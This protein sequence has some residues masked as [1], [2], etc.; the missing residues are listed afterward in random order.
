LY[1]IGIRPKGVLRNINEIIGNSK[2]TDNEQ[3]Q[4]QDSKAEYLGDP[5]TPR[6]KYLTGMILLLFLKIHHIV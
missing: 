4:A 1:V 2:D 5:V 3:A 6:T